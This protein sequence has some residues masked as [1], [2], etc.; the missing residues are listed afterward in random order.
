[1]KKVLLIGL[2][3]GVV[4]STASAA[5][6]IYETFEPPAAAV[7]PGGFLYYADNSSNGGGI[8]G[9]DIFNVD[10]INNAYGAIGGGI[11]L[12]LNGNS[13]GSISRTFNTIAGYTYTLTFDR[14]T[15][16][17]GESFDL[18]FG[19]NPVV[20]FSPSTVTG[21]G[22][23]IQSFIGTGAVA[24]L[25]FTGSAGGS[26]GGSVLDNIS[27]TSAVPEPGEWAMMLAGLGAVS[28][29]AKR[30]RLDK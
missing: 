24:T 4:A 15:N 20:N 7:A 28:L 8:A 30:R 10:L 27:V 16:G 26:N 22:A 18:V 23:N 6:I 3:S 29:I 25:S 1:M 21:A 11:S 17:T 2:L 19:S 12:D 9:W 13:P 5:T 14:S